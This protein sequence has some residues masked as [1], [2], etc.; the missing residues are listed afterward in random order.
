MP[1][2]S[3][4]VNY[5]FSIRF[6]ATTLAGVVVYA[7]HYEYPSI[8]L[9]FDLCLTYVGDVSYSFY[10]VH[11]PIIL[12]GR[13]A[14]MDS[15]IFGFSSIIIL[16]IVVAVLLYEFLDKL[17]STKAGFMVFTQTGIIFG[18]ILI[19]CLNMLSLNMN[20]TEQ[21]VE[22]FKKFIHNLS[23]QEVIQVNEDIEK[24][25][26]KSPL[27]D[28]HNES[29]L[30]AMY[31]DAHFGKEWS[32]TCVVDYNKNGT[33]TIALLGNSFASR[34]S[35][36]AEKGLKEFSNVKKLYV[37]TR[38]ACTIFDTLN[39]VGESRWRCNDLIGKT[40]A[41]LKEVRPDIIIHISR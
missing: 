37:I 25:C 22:V 13:Y 38:A 20:P 30:S 27:L 16:C 24:S 6:L 26:Y 36:T 35:I 28:C 18:I 10:L 8:P 3:M 40:I 9:A 21:K 11:W 2:V 12:F 19:L 33:K 14:S 17:I 31:P 39:A 23:I 1:E 4:S 5:K 7:G 29:A 32:N 34:F 15:T 41:F